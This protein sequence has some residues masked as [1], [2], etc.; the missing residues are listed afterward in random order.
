MD[1][2][3]RASARYISRQHLLQG[4]ALGW[5]EELY[6]LAGGD[7]SIIPWADLVPNPNLV[8]WLDRHLVR[9]DGK[10][11]VKVGCGLGD[12]AE[13]LVRH[14]FITTAFD[15][16]QTAIAWCRRRFPN[17]KVKYQT[18]D[19]FE[20]PSVWH[21]SFDFVLESYTLQVLPPRLRKKAISAISE[22]VADGG[23]LLVISRGKEMEDPEGKMPWPLSRSGLEDFK[24]C[25]LAEISFED[26]M[27]HEEPP[28]RRFRVVY[29]R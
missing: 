12:D 9:G 21:R 15:I 10:R 11:A 13:E 14:G 28:V 17:S 27:D 26:Y 8:D 4:N 22:F 25:G 7:A 16:S 18:V 5:F 19:L 1:E 20:A 2:S 24:K 6:A 23:T 3:H 29:E